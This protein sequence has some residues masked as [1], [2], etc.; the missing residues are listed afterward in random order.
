MRD[1]A[2][3]GAG[4]FGCAIAFEFA[5]RGSDVLLL[6]Q[7]ADIL[8]GASALNQNRLH[9]GFHYPRDATTARQSLV[10]ARLFADRFPESIN[11]SFPNYYFVA[12]DGSRTS[13]SEFEGF[14]NEHR[15]PAQRLTTD[16]YPALAASTEKLDGAWR[17]AE[18][19]IDMSILHDSF[20]SLL[21]DVGVDI[22]TKCQV[23]HLERTADGNWCIETN[24]GPFR[25]RLIVIATY[26]LDRLEPESDFL[27]EFQETLVPIATSPS[28]PIGLT[29][30]D[31]DFVTVLPRG[32]TNELLLYSPGLSVL[33]RHVGTSVIRTQR[34]DPAKV[35]QRI[36]AIIARV[37]D[38]FPGL[39]LTDTGV[40]LQTTRRIPAHAE[41]TDQRRSTFSEVAP[42]CY[43][44]HSGKVD[45]CLTL[46]KNLADTVY[47]SHSKTSP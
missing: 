17:V 32:F 33:S 6:E 25:S 28:K 35:K 3:V 16:Q 44:V 1:V 15:L 45:H 29:V 4:A 47:I 39:E 30:V 10:G 37:L 34:I 18:G 31:G 27:S 22:R 2:V 36:S 42:R 9:V 12:R 24:A 41:A 13:S 21:N 7:E 46:A 11:L 40:C 23:V 43:R 14:I 38:F 26:G 5:A 20:E 8:L 19:V